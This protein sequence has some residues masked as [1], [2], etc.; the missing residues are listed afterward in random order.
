VH[1][2]WR[3][4]LLNKPAGQGFRTPKPSPA[5]I[6]AFECITEVNRNGAYANILLPQLLE[7]SS[8]EERDRAFATELSYGTLR[9]QG[10]YDWAIAHQADR[11]F[12]ELDSKVVDLLRIGLHQIWAMRVPDHAAVSETVELA[13]Y[14][15]GESKATFVNAILRNIMRNPDAINTFLAD[16]A[17]PELERLAIE[18]SH[19]TWIISAFYDQ[20]KDWDRVRSL[21]EI[22]NVPVAPHL[23]A[24][25]GKS[26]PEELMQLGGTPLNPSR[27]GVLS[28]HS[29]LSYPPIMERRAGVQ[30]LGSQLLT[31]YFFDLSET[32]REDHQSL[33]WLDLCA[34]PGGKSALL[35]NLLET[36]Y[37]EDS[38]VANEPTA[39][40]ADLVARVVPRQKILSHDGR[41]PELFPQN[42]DRILVDAPCTGLG[43]LRRR[44]EAR[45]RKSL[46]DLKEL[47]PL[48]RDLID[49]A[50]ELLNP[51]GLL[52]Y[53]T[54]SPHIA[55]TV[56]QVLD[57]QYRHKDLSVVSL[58][59]AIAP[60]NYQ[61]KI[62]GTMQ[63]WTDRDG[64]DSMF[65]A[66]FQKA[67]G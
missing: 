3:A 62:A 64:T 60:E 26:T 45:W 44:P 42:Y 61:G 58:F 66:V 8:L 29:P 52:A 7:K 11:P 34:G 59:N 1:D 12:A 50:Y 37:P 55:E 30:D 49:G 24:W 22:D 47:I 18:F 25:P 32:I 48:Q 28:E 65:M 2:L 4:S 23:V 57:A 10:R 15:A 56:G 17:K 39:H 36:S 33:A 67:H 31:Q 38:F 41:Y 20:L 63:L 54:C 5:R 19:P 35:Y 6:I 13:R 16:S 40:R 46:S 53:A 21:L 27:F 9:M 51:G 43:A 14:A